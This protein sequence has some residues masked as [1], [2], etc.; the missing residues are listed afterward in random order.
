MLS[1]GVYKRYFVLQ[2]LLAEQY[3]KHPIFILKDVKFQELKAMMDYMYRGEVNISQDQL[4]ALLK[5]AESLQIKGLSDSRGKN[6]SEPRKAAPPPPPVKTPPPAPTIPRVQGLTI[7]Q[8]KAPKMSSLEIEDSR[9]REG[10]SSPVPRKRKKP[11]RRSM[12][13]VIDNHDASNSSESHSN[14]TPA[15]NIPPAIPLASTSKLSTDVPEQAESKSDILRQ[16]TPTSDS[17]LPQVPNIR[18]KLETHS[19][20]ILEPKSEYLDEELMNEDSV[21]DL[22]LDDD[23]INNME[24]MDHSKPGP[25]HGSGDGSSQGT[26]FL[27][28]SHEH[29]VPEYSFVLLKISVF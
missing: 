6:D 17:D 14:Q 2:A 23:D 1:D 25:S 5:A 22:T 26:S 7:E 29:K 15:Q 28:N 4:A 27:L 21:E 13:S 8:R 9:S 20:L 24:G 11:R 19:E 10:S 3:D 12:E 16:K 18:E